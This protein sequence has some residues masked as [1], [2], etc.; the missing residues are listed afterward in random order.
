MKIIKKLLV[1]F[2]LCCCGAVF[3]QSYQIGDVYTAPD[4]SRGIVYYLHPDGSGG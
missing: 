3:A 4:G 2:F 1:I